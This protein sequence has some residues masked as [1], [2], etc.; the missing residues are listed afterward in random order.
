MHKNTVRNLYKILQKT[1]YCVFSSKSEIITTFCVDIVIFGT[2]Y[3]ALREQKRFLDALFSAEGRKNMRKTS[4]PKDIYDCALLS[5]PNAMGRYNFGRMS[6]MNLAE[7]ANAVIR[8]GRSI[9]IVTAK[10]D[11][12]ISMQSDNEARL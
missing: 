1:F 7:A 11:Q 3:R 8:F 6:M 9:R 4:K 2:D 10:V 5:V 12:F